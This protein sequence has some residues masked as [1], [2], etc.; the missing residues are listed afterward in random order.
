MELD[1][2]KPHA[3]I[4][5]DDEGRAYEQD[6]CFFTATGALWTAPTG[7]PAAD[8]PARPARRRAT[9]APP[10]ASEADAQIAAQLG[11]SQG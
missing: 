10:P 1:K 7:A 6:G 2:L 8:A 5:G 3:V 11:D 4:V 9:E